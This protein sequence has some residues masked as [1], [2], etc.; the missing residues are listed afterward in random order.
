[1][2]RFLYRAE[3]LRDRDFVQAMEARLARGDELALHGF[4][5]IDDAPPPR[6][7]RDWFERRMLTRT[8]GEF[9]ALDENAAERRIARGVALFEALGWPLAGFVP[10]A[11]LLSPGAR[12]AL[13][14]CDHRFE[15]VTARSGMF[16]LPGWRFE[17][18]ANLWYSPTGAPRRVLS[19]IAIQ[20]ELFRARTRALL[21]VSLHPQD[22]RVRSVLEHWRRII[23]RVLAQRTP[24]TKRAWT[25]RFKAATL[26]H[27]A[28]PTHA[29]AHEDAI[30]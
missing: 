28:T 2:P 27:P 5:H 18:T 25:Q 17:R 13:E 29:I 30:A 11:W 14:R 6:N 8:E 23:V 22:A 3:V 7:L 16:H 21:R 9:A 20:R 10:P 15:Y 1:V 12:I 4:F 26:R 19:A 24:V